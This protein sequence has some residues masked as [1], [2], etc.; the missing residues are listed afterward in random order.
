MNNYLLVT[1][2]PV[3][4]VLFI[5]IF[6]RHYGYFAFRKSSDSD[7]S[8]P[9]LLPEDTTAQSVSLNFFRRIYPLEVKDYL[10][11]ALITVIYGVVAFC[12]IGDHAAPQS[13]C[14]YDDRGMYTLIELKEPTI[15]SRVS[16][17]T[18]LYTGDY[19]LQ[20]SEDGENYVDQTAMSQPHSNLFKWL[21]AELL[22][23][24]TLTRFVRI[25]AGSQLELGELVLYDNFGRRL[26]PDMLIY[27][28]GTA[29]LF[30]EQELIPDEFTFLNSAYFDEIYHA[31]T[32]YENV[33]NVYPYEISHPPLGKLIISSGV[34]LFGMTPFG[35]RFMG[36]LFGIL[37]LPCL[38]LLLKNMFGS[39]SIATCGTL[40]FAFDFMHY[41]QTRIATIDTYGVF[42]TILMYLFMYRFIA[43]DPDDPFSKRKQIIALLLSGLCFGLGAASKWTCI[44]AGGGLAVLWLLYWI[45]R[46]RDLLAAGQKKTLQTA[47][48]KNILLCLL[49]FVLLPALIYYL[50]YYPYGKAL[51][52]SA[53]SM[54]FSKEYATTVL[55]N[56]KFMFSYHSGVDATHPYSSMWYQWILNIRPILYY[57]ESSHSTLKS[58]FGAFLNP[59]L[60]WGGLFAMIAMAILVIRDRDGRALF[61]LIGYLAQLAPWILISR[62]VFEYHYFPSTIFLTLAL[63][64][65]FDTLRRKDPRWKRW[66]YPFTAV[67]V[68]LFIMFYPVLSGLPVPRW[69]TS[70]FLQWLPSW[71]F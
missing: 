8:D 7:M 33:T 60:C 43:T 58:A 38:Y 30:D 1:L 36:V 71:P 53:P 16:Y 17:Y 27:D 15:L 47:L 26:P 69:Y 42:F 44:Y 67:A 41:V 10:P 70:N 52:L 35:W 29:P 59:I 57:L 21:D 56:Q 22:P 34:H 40:L 25:I 65:V 5:L 13:F 4:C 11:M 54:Y 9:S 50:S 49:C 46:G 19:Y 6:F 28:E 18:G 51:G 66:V 32:A 62:V 12:M 3:L 39:T 31:R 45:F 2:F 63:S 64:H 61:I 20:F 68:G 14:K 37:M 24:Q 55:D 48:C 23:D